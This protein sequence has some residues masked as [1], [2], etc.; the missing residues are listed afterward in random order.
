MN[1][2]KTLTT[3]IIL[4]LAIGQ[5][6]AQSFNK[7]LMGIIEEVETNETE[8]ALNMCRSLEPKYSS[9]WELNYL[10]AQIYLRT[11]QYSLALQKINAALK[12]EHHDKIACRLL[13]GIIYYHQKEYSEVIEDMNFVKKEADAPYMKNHYNLNW[14]KT[15]SRYH[16]SLAAIKSGEYTIARS[17]FDS[18]CA[19]PTTDLSSLFYQ[20][21][22][23]WKGGNLSKSH[24]NAKTI[25]DAFSIHTIP[26]ADKHAEDF[27]FD[28]LA[29]REVVRSALKNYKSQ[30][31]VFLNTDDLDENK[32]L[33]NSMFKDLDLAWKFVIPIHDSVDFALRDSLISAFIYVV[34]MLAEVPV[35]NEEAREHV[36][37]ANVFNE[38]K[39]YRKASEAYTM[40]L[41][42]APWYANGYYNRSLIRSM[43]NDYT[44]AISDMEYFL[45]FNSS[46]TDSRSAKDKIYEWRLKKS[47]QTG[48]TEIQKSTTIHTDFLRNYLWEKERNR[49]SRIY[50]QA[51]G[52]A[53]MAMQ[54]NNIG[55]LPA[56]LASPEITFKYDYG[57]SVL[58]IRRLAI[59]II[60]GGI[61]GLGASDD[62]I[63]IHHTYTGIFTDIYVN[64]KN[65][66]GEHNFF[67][68]S[69]GNSRF[70]GSGK[71]ATNLRSYSFDENSKYYEIGFG[72]GGRSGNF[73]FGNYFGYY[74]SQFKKMNYTITKSTNPFEIGS[75]NSWPGSDKTRPASVY[76][77]RI[78]ISLTM[79]LYF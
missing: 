7:Q 12:D 41:R 42:A 32:K 19:K 27:V 52:T 55:N 67:R 6:K 24:Q 75:K 28:T 62:S 33:V 74:H 14:F 34:P 4:S 26:I 39:E 73:Y 47:A 21:Y 68:L 8:K 58:P 30:L 40:A 23:H 43:I 49:K 13:R 44:G 48:N 61:S 10:E 45:K 76:Y 63:S 3:F 50:V 1:R 25:L 5:V 2:L 15:V 54:Y 46:S 31:K 53:A 17:D 16:R 65:S 64:K 60:K 56:S 77:D 72:M 38:E 9:E 11:G 35:I 18:I 71:E 22:A 36:V 37:Q 79:G 59:G 69:V 66:S 70:Y 57:I 51:F 78:L 29:R 20:G